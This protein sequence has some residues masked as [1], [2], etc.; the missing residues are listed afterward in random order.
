MDNARRSKGGS[1]FNVLTAALALG[2]TRGIFHSNWT[3]NVKRF[4]YYGLFRLGFERHP[5]PAGK[6]FLL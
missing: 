1:G 4:K 6:A 5:D 2:G 3:S